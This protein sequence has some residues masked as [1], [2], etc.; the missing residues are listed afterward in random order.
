MIRF[1]PEGVVRY[2]NPC[3]AMLLLDAGE[4]FITADEERASGNSRRRDKAFG[5][6][7]PPASLVR[8]SLAGRTILL[9]H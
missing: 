5:K 3:R 6:A 8:G 1:Q 9:S 7:I 4:L 2:V